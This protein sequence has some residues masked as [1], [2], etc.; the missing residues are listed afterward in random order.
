MPGSGSGPG[1]GAVARGQPAGPGPEP[2]V[3]ALTADGPEV[4]GGR[5]HIF[6]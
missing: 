1:P 3:E 5:R 2:G 4:R 6:S